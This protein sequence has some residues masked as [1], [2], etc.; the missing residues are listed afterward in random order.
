MDNIEDCYIDIDG[1]KTRY[2]EI[3]SNGVPVVLLHGIC[4]S[5]EEWRE[6]VLALSAKHRVF[7]V[8][9]I[10]YGLTDK[11]TN[12]TYSIRRLAQFT[13]DFLTAKKIECAHF[14]GNSMGGRIALE[15]ALMAPERVSSM[16]LVAP[17]GVGRETVMTLRLA[18]LPVLGDMLTRPSCHGVKMLWKG[19]FYDASLVTDELVETKYK[20]ASMPGAHKAFLKTLRSF[21]SLGGFMRGQLE[22]LHT[23][24][25]SLGMQVLVVWGKQDNFLPVAHAKILKRLLPNAKIELVDECGHAP[26]IEKASLF[27]KMVLNFWGD[28]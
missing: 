21:V 6:N 7:A 26:Q 12:E 4:C 2:W 8:D 22:S 23:E 25:P 15:C 9:L 27:N 24:L 13:I 18:T 28:E 3:G 11:P 10:G 16:V 17:A 19:A 5:V 1:I 14:V 20:Y